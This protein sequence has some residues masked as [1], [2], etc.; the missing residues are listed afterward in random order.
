MEYTLISLIFY[1]FASVKVY[2]NYGKRQENEL[3]I[4]DVVLGVILMD[5]FFLMFAKL[6]YV[7]FGQTL[8]FEI[9]FSMEIIFFMASYVKR[10]GTD[11]KIPTYLYY[12]ICLVHGYIIFTSVLNL[13][14]IPNYGLV[15]ALLFHIITKVFCE[16]LIE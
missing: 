10:I 12:I 7:L 4:P 16:L 15:I 1:I 13:T 6:F 9:L 3:N 11:K 2:R 14:L 5:V 8:I